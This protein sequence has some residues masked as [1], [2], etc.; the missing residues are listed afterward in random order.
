MG[1]RYETDAL[2]GVPLPSGV[3]SR[4][5]LAWS[6]QQ[7]VVQWQKL[8]VAPPLVERWLNGQCS[9]VERMAAEAIIERWRKRLFDISW[10]MRCLNE[11]IARLA[12][13]SVAWISLQN[14]IW[15]ATALLDPKQALGND[16]AD[17]IGDEVSDHAGGQVSTP[18][19]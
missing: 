15:R 4:F 18:E 16:K 6:L 14:F 13:A 7:V 11:H 3:V 5:L 2:M 10:F 12:V 8:F 19:I 1:G 17:A 9:E